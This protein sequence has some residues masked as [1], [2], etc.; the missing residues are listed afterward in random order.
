MIS[1]YIRATVKNPTGVAALTQAISAAHLR[2]QRVRVTGYVRRSADSGY[3]QLFLRVEGQGLTLAKNHAATTEFVPA[4]NS[5]DHGSWIQ[6]SIVVDVPE[7]STGL[8]IGFVSMGAEEAWLDDVRF[9]LV[10]KTV[11]L[12][13][14]AIGSPTSLGTTE[15]IARDVTQQESAYRKLAMEFVNLDF[16]SLRLSRR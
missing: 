2:G 10:N 8:R 14:T 4:R 13:G 12:I 11:S 9:E 16:E 5:E 15:D 7:Y 6:Q 3:A 1:G